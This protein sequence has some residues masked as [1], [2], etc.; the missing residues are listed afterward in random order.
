MK[1]ASVAVTGDE[2]GQV[3]TIG[4]RFAA[5]T[6]ISV[7]VGQAYLALARGQ[8]IGNFSATDQIAAAPAASPSGGASVAVAEQP[9]PPTASRS[10]RGN[11]LEAAPAAQAPLPQAVADPVSRRRR[12]APPAAAAQPSPAS[13]PS[14]AGVGN[15]ASGTSRRR[16]APASAPQTQLVVAGELSDADLSKAASEAARVLT[17][18]VVMGIL[19]D[20]GVK[21]TQDLKGADR[22]KFVDTLKAKAGA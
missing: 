4:L 13:A 20:F 6:D 19:A 5:L 7:L 3:V 22:R 1:I 2:T 17:P 16:Q 11:P 18:K 21:G 8:E 9:A 15:P 10:R 12:A 14:P